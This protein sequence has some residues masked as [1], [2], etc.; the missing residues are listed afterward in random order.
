MIHSHVELTMHVASNDGSTVLSKH[1]YIW[2]LTLISKVLGIG[3]I[4][5][6]ISDQNQ[7]PKKVMTCRSPMGH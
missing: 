7:S 5:T 1:V 3:N 6:L 4:L 2:E